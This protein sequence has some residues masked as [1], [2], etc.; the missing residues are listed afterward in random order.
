MELTMYA[1]AKINLTLDITGVKVNGYHL[2]SMIM[3]SVDLHDTVTLSSNK[4]GSITVISNNNMLPIGAEN[5]AF[6]AA[7]DFFNALHIE[8]EGMEIGIDKK[9]PIAAGLGG[10][11]SDAAAVLL[12][13]NKL[14][15]EHF[16]KEDLASLA[17]KI[18]TD[19][20]FFLQGGTALAEGVGEVLTPLQNLPE[21]YFVLVKPCKKLSTGH[22]YRLVDNQTTLIHP[23]NKLVVKAIYDGSLLN[24]SGLLCNLFDEVWE[25]TEIDSAKQALTKEGAIGVSLSGSGPTV[26]GMF[27]KSSDAKLAAKRLKNQFDEV[28]VCKSVKQGVEFL[29]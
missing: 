22:M 15:D 20:P 11:S 9:I 1:N 7:V 24:L 14:Y 12:G 23:S 2:L 26:F 16:T 17:L 10:G 5:I 25:S 13:L 21:C 19:V 28:F 6:T 3:Q 27:I 29:D 4:S 18:G 8:C